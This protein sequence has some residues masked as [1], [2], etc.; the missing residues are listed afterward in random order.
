MIAFRVIGPGRAGLSLSAALEAREGF[1][2]RGILGRSDPLAGAAH[3]VDLLVVATPDDTVAT[4]ASSVTPCASTVVAHLSGSLRLDVLHAHPRR[5]SLH[6]LVPLP[7]PEVGRHRLGSG[8]AFAVSGDPLLARVVRALGGS[9]F[10]V[11]DPERARYHAAAAIA[12]NHLVAL[13]GQVERVAASIGL[14]LAAFEGLMRSAL[15]DAISLGPRQAL[16]GPAARGDWETVGRHREELGRLPGARL[17]LAGYDAMVDL[18]RRLSLDAASGPGSV[19]AGS[20]P[21]GPVPA[22]SEAASAGLP[23]AVSPEERVA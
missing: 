11:R 5:G 16:T 15:D 2:L 17:E 4:V 7:T 19:P 20:V 21:A 3:G 14:P 13:T 1:E 6:P 8:V 12:A 10:A 23:G 22:G 9:A 18:A